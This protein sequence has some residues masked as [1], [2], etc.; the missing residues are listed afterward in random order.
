[1][2]LLRS[3]FAGTPMGPPPRP[4]DWDDY[5][6]GDRGARSTAGP[7]I[8]EEVAL[9]I[10][11]VYACVDKLQKAFKIAPCHLT[12]TLPDDADGHPQGV[13]DA[14]DHW[15]YPLLHDQPNARQTATEFWAEC[16]AHLALRGAFYAEKT[17][18]RGVE[19]T[20]LTLLHPD[21]VEPR[22]LPNG[23]RGFR[24]TRDNG[25]KDPL[26]QDEVFCVIALSLDG[27][28]T[29]VSP[30]RYAREAIGRAV[31]T[32]QYASRTFSQGALHRAVL[33]HPGQ[34]SPTAQ[35]N[36]KQSIVEQTSGAA[37]WHQPL[38]L[39]EGMKYEPLTMTPEDT[40]M[41]LSRRF[42]VADAARFFDV[43]LVMINESAGATMWGSGLEQLMQG[44]V[45]WAC[46]PAARDIESAI[47]R[48]LVPEDERASLRARFNLDALLRADTATRY[49]AH[50]VGIMN[51]FESEN[52]VRLMEG[53]NPRP[54]LW[55]PRRSA[56]Q[57]RGGNPNAPTPP[58]RAAPPAPPPDETDP[59]TAR[60]RQ[61]AEANARLLVRRE[62]ATL[63]AQPEGKRQD[64]AAWMKFV[65]DFYGHHAVALTEALCLDVPAA[66]RYCAAHCAEL[67]ER[68]M[69][70]LETWELEA[71]LALT[72]L[73]LG[74]TGTVEDALATTVA[75][76]A[77][78]SQRPITA[79]I[80][81]NAPTTITDGAVQVQHVESL[82]EPAPPVAFTVKKS[83]VRDPATGRAT[84][85]VEEHTPAPSPPSPKKPT[86]RK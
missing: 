56:N 67:L 44:F 27:G 14:T 35:A 55:E 46:L 18:G 12:E 81:V 59:A 37:N 82:T 5:W 58:G 8:T 61:L 43:P 69:D 17:F 60:G 9:T 38:I 25:T 26:T 32:E 22:K 49:N 23:R 84:G 48:D 70:S 53:L 30:L 76:V 62:L 86:R 83:L 65:T 16:R 34:L 15:L 64:A 47:L 31:A 2:G 74:G 52:E 11:A 57:D 28:W 41:L 21:T 33:S 10:G 6:Y 19:V 75:A 1:M 79:D 51:G 39:E 3:L 29:P 42:S 50:A 54:G 4:S 72:A 71:P 85:V 24:V 78:L 45:T 7:R 66:R 13:N 77:R 63:R 20:A 68:G 40:Q 80:T 36:L 73:A